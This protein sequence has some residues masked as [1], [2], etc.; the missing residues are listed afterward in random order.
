MYSSVWVSIV[1]NY[2]LTCTTFI[3]YSSFL[4]AREMWNTWWKKAL[5]L[6]IPAIFYALLASGSEW[7]VIQAGLFN[8]TFLSFVLTFGCF[9]ITA[10]LLFSGSVLRKILLAL[11]AQI[12]GILGEAVGLAIVTLCLPIEIVSLS[13]NDS[14]LFFAMYAIQLLFDL[15]IVLLIRLYRDKKRASVT[16][17][18]LIPLVAMLLGSVAYIVILPSLN[19][20]SFN[21]MEGDN[22]RMFLLCVVFVLA[23][24]GIV[25]I[26]FFRQQ[27]MTSEEYTE[28]LI[29]QDIQLREQYYNELEAHHREIRTMRHDLKNQLLAACEGRDMAEFNDLLMSLEEMG[30]AYTANHGLNRLILAKKRKAEECGIQCDFTVEIPESTHFKQLDIGALIGNIMDNAIEA[31]QHC[32]ADRMFKLELL[33]QGHALIIR[34]ENSTDGVVDTTITRKPDK[35]MHG[36]GMRSIESIVRKYNGTCT[37]EVQDGRFVLEAL[38]WEPKCTTGTPSVDQF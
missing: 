15:V 29:E 35:A 8:A 25:M 18:P 22:L 28:M 27:K 34:S 30:V 16:K 2:F 7:L 21:N 23:A 37:W 36:L 38:L 10:E 4:P 32:P 19:G 17:P 33:Y 11:F 31:C 20:L 5:V 12:L 14:S 26:W 3:L 9:L 6:V 24:N 13:S 1:L